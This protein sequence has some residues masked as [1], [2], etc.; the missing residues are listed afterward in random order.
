M[1]ENI[2]KGDSIAK[3]LDGVLAEPE[4]AGVFQT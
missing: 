1:I 2:V 4:K 3:V